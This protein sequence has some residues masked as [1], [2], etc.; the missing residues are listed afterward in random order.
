MALITKEGDQAEKV[1]DA[2]KIEFPC[3]NYVI[4]VVSLDVE[5]IHTEITER[6]LVHAPEMD[7][8]AENINRSSKGRFI[9]FSFRIVAHSEDQLSALHRDLMSLDAVKMVL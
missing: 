9:S 8:A 6:L 2:P 7:T 1:L 4:K 3:E 5:G